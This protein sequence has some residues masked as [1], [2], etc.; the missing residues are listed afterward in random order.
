MAC[1]QLV[2]ISQIPPGHIDRTFPPIGFLIENNVN[3]THRQI[4]S[5]FFSGVPYQA[6]IP[7]A[8]EYKLFSYGQTCF[9]DFDDSNF[10]RFDRNAIQQVDQF[11]LPHAKKCERADEFIS[12]IT[13]MNEV[14]SDC[15]R[16]LF[17]T[18]DTAINCQ[19][20]GDITKVKTVTGNKGAVCPFS[21]VIT[22]ISCLSSGVRTDDD[23]FSI[24]CIEMELTCEKMNFIPGYIPNKQ[25]D[26]T[27]NDNKTSTVI[28][29]GLSIGLPLLIVLGL[30]CLCCLPD[31]VIAINPSS[32]PIQEQSSIKDYENGPINNYTMRKRNRF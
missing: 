15:R 5:E 22:G 31:D 20:S 30:V 19:L 10:K 2:L 26:D 8:N 21:T 11:G 29:I 14:G 17:F 1:Q 27:A 3:G 28:I 12:S 4:G 24:P 25:Y 7:G 23:K 18:C 9:V 16:G 32:I 13:C 6:I